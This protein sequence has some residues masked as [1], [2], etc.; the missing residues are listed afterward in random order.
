MI[1]K[2]QEQPYEV[3][4]NITFSDLNVIDGIQRLWTQYVMWVRALLMAL[5]FDDPN[6][7]AILNRLY[8][9]PL[10]FYNTLRIF[11]G[12]QIAQEM[13]NYLQR[14]LIIEGRLINAMITGGQ[15]SVDAYTLEYYKNADE[16]AEYLG[17]FPYWDAARWQTLLYNDISMTFDEIQAILLGEYEREID[18][19]ERIL[20]NATTIGRYMAAGILENLASPRPAAGS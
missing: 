6:L 19:Y 11:Y 16:L 5:A 8:R 18:I 3:F 13:M 12:D 7:A 20:N 2:L 4:Y 17:R 1:H 10:D 15:E 9:V 14:R